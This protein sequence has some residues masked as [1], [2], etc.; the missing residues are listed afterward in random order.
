MDCRKKIKSKG[1]N[2]DLAASARVENNAFV[3]VAWMEVDTNRSRAE[4]NRENLENFLEPSTDAH[5]TWRP[6]LKAMRRNY[7][8]LLEKKKYNRKI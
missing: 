2:K 7:I 3:A 4:W 8:P 6:F 5:S 1:M